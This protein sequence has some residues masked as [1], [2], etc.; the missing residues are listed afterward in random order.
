MPTINESNV[1][2]ASIQYLEE[3]GFLREQAIEALVHNNN[4]VERAIEWILK[5]GDDDDNNTPP[6]PLQEPNED[7]QVYIMYIIF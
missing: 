2:S 1:S 5:R 4:N 7:D 3:M 6:P